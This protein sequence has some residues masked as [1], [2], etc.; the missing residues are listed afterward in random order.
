M[1]IFKVLATRHTF[2]E[3]QMSTLLAWLMHPKEAHGLGSLF[4]GRFIKAV[5]G[6]KNPDLAQRLT[7]LPCDMIKCSLEEHVRGMKKGAYIDIVYF[8]DD[9]LIAVEN[10]IYIGSIEKGQLVREYNGLRKKYDDKKIIMVYLVPDIIWQSDEEYNSLQNIVIA[11]DMRAIISW[12]DTICSLIEGLL[13]DVEA[14]ALEPIP[15][16][17]KLTLE[18]LLEFVQDNYAGCDFNEREFSSSTEFPRSSYAELKKKTVGYVGVKHGIAGLIRMDKI[19]ISSHGFQYD[20]SHECDRQHWI[21]LNDFLAVAKLLIEGAD[22][23][24]DFKQHLDSESIYKIICQSVSDNIYVGIRGGEKKLLEMSKEEI[25]EK[26]WGVT[27]SDPPTNQWIQG[28]RYRQIYE[29]KFG[30]NGL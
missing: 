4:Y 22:L 9:V 1:N 25:E 13:S 30:V 23:P 10:K 24:A 28:S 2:K 17:T 3:E 29:E 18:S 6:D 20:P 5:I 27:N 26:S 11:T 14:C 19:C 15:I 21:H 8:L 16:N 7:D 12:S